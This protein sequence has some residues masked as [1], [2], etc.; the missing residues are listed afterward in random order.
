M[1]VPPHLLWMPILAERDTA[2]GD[3]DTQR[4]TTNSIVVLCIAP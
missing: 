3:L 4:D 1:E 2:G